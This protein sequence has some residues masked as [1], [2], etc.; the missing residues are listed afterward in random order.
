MSNNRNRKRRSGNPAVRAEGK[1]PEAIDFD[2]I[3]AQKRR[4]LGEIRPIRIGGKDYTLAPTLPLAVTEFFAEG[5]AADDNKN[6]TAKL[7]DM[8]GV[9]ALLFGE[10]AWAEITKIIDITEVAPLFNTVFAA[11]GES[12]GES[13]PSGQS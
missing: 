9:L 6:V 2:T 5:T 1:M 13:E 11:Y 7:A 10:E 3:R 8:Q 4:V 12:V